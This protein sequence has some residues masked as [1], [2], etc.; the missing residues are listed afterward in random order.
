MTSKERLIAAMKRQATDYVPCLPAFWSTPQVEG[1][2]WANEVERLEVIIGKLGA[3]AITHFGVDVRI[4]PDVSWRVWEEQRPGEPYPLLVKEVETPRGTLRAVVRKTEDW[5]HGQDIPFV[6]DFNVS[7]YVKPWLESLEDVERF[8]YCHL[9]PGDQQ[10][11]KARQRWRHLAP[12]VEMFQVPVLATYTLGLTAALSL[13]GVEGGALLSMDEPETFDR[14]SEIVHQTA[15]GCLEILL[16]LG[17]DVVRRNGWY[18]STDFWSPKQ[19][20]RYIRPHVEKEIAMAHDAG[21]IFNYTMCTG[22]MPLIPILAEMDF[23]YLDTIEP[24]LGGQDMHRIASE[25]GRTKCLGGGV[26]APIHI[27]EGKPDDVRV[28]VR[29]AI[30]VFGREGFILTAVPSIRPQWP[31]E[32]VIAMIDE[33]KALRA[34]G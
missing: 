6:S 26:S 30:E 24:V 29:K 16:D 27:G 25:L 23:D 22:I 33:W 20:A 18:E 31:W 1:Y 7:R 3:D 10:V 32:N 8:A 17:V 5:P 11:E 28:A 14:F 15:V 19:Y 9:P 4:H 2:Q 13:F 34:Q 12:I 21:C